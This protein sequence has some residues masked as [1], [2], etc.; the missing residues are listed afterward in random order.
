ML[1]GLSFELV[2]ND[3]V[4]VHVHD[5]EEDNSA[6]E[7]M[8]HIEKMQFKDKINKFIQDSWRELMIND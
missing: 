7:S 1:E 4:H 6:F 3:K 5:G 8:D 2:S